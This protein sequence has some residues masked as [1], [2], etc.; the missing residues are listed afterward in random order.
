M[1]EQVSVSRDIAA[2]PEKVWAMVSDVTRMGDWSPETTVARWLDDATGP[3]PGARFR[4]SNRIEWRRWQ[5]VATVTEAEPGRSF[6][7]RVSAGPIEVA[8]WSYTFEPTAAGCRVTESWTDR[9]PG[10]F[11]PIAWLATGVRDRA[12]HNRA[13]MDETL[14]RLAYLAERA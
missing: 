8:E 14:E 4:G 9:R 2:P 13:G 11:K 6:A 5:T 7:F 12:E 1:T 10:Y 3:A